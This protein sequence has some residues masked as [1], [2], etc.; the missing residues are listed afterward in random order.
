MRTKIVGVGNT[1]DSYGEKFISA[2]HDKNQRNYYEGSNYNNNKRRNY[3]DERN[4]D[5]MG[6][7]DHYN[8]S[9]SLNERIGDIVEGVNKL[10]EMQ[11]NK[12]D[13]NSKTTD[14]KHNTNKETPAEDLKDIDFLDLGKNEEVGQK[15]KPVNEDVNFLDM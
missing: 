13:A 7:Y 5:N 15:K 8:G 2:P 6:S 14:D 9:K 4:L 1:I 11:K 10:E 3:M 12:K